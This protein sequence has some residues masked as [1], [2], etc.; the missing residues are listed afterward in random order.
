MPL[1]RRLAGLG[2][3]LAAYAPFH[4]LLDV[5]RTGPAGRA[6]RDAAEAAWV[7]GLSGT[8]IVAT[9]AWLGVRMSPPKPDGPDPLE[10]IER[11]V[12]TPRP[13]AF[14]LFTGLASMAL[15][16]LVASVVH[17]RSPTSVDEMAQLLHAAAVAGGRL[18][19]PV[20]GNGASWA[21][22]NGV[23]T[24]VGWASV[25]PPL[26]TM[27]LAIGV[28]SHAA[29]LVGPM[30]TGLATGCT[31][32]AADRLLGPVTG[33][34]AGLLL[35][36]SPFWLLLGATHSSHAAAAAG[37][38]MALV[39][40]TQARDG[41][42]GW[43]VATGAAVGVAVCARPWIGLVCS[44]AIVAALW[45]D[46]RDRTPARVIGVISGGAPFAALLLWWNAALFGSPW[47]LGYSVAFGPAHGL[48]FHDDPWGNRYGV[49]EAIGYTG[50][51]LVQ[52][53]TRI[54]ESPLPTTALIGAALLVG[55]L[56]AGARVFGAWVV[57]G[58]V[59]TA[60]YWHHGI[61]FGPRMLYETLPA[62]SVLL[63]SSA[64]ALL[65]RGRGEDAPT[66]T[67]D[68]VP[69][70]LLV[71][72]IVG[73]MA[74]A[75]SALRNAAL[76]PPPARQPLPSAQPAVIFVHG[77]W[78]SRVSGRLVSAGMRRDSVETALRRNDICA[79]DSYARWRVAGDPGP[80]PLL[81]LNPLPGT[82]AS[83]S[84][85]T[86]S[87][88]N[89]VRVDPSSAFDAACAREARADRLGTLELELVAW[90][91]PP[92]PGEPVFVARDLGPAANAR[93]LGALNRTPYVLVEREGVRF[94]VEYA[95][96]M[97]M[98]WGGAAGELVR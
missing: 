88:G 21:A 91:H 82:P 1:V 73:G 11:W 44:I 7:V 55:P 79:V 98:L 8:V 41:H 78:A 68:R 20:V 9:L 2:L 5:E 60:A 40:A 24:E 43:S 77:S 84:T 17:D 19:V 33:R 16:A 13:A 62:W 10:R 69:R 34:V 28:A 29:W 57:A 12:R 53:G 32:W 93:T 54:F 94:L 72:S 95:E 15:C 80:E 76:G 97:E 65:G 27:L 48:G 59:A 83:L 87:P 52:L 58:L 46:R 3:L 89:L 26:H 25:Y 36:V 23:M 47:R 92:I 71:I 30:L 51:D 66:R 14:A 96:G 38:T 18:A 90:R 22:Q 74:L 81:D 86:L 56:G 37:L 31:T 42:I 70:W 64:A 39:S 6:T 63:A 49:I 61:H 45:W 35:L 75:P 4:R 50:A 67:A 85:R